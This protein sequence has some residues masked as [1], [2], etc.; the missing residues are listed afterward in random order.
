MILSSHIPSSITDM[1]ELRF[2]ILVLPDHVNFIDGNEYFQRITQYIDSLDLTYDSIW[3]PDHLLPVSGGMKNRI[4]R[5]EFRKGYFECLSLTSYLLPLYPNHKFGQIVLC[6]NFRN[7]ALLAKI[8]STLQVLSNGR[9]ILGLGAGWFPEEHKQYGFDYPSRRKRVERLDEAVK[10][11]KMLWQD[12]DVTFNGK[13]YRIENAFCNPKPDP[14]PP[15]MIGGGG[16]KYTL[17]LVANYADW[18]NGAWYSVE[19]W[20]HKLGVLANHCDDVGRDFDDLVKSALYGISVASTD[21]DALR[22]AKNCPYYSTST[23]ITGGPETLAL[24]LGSL[25]DAGVEFFHL[26]FPQHKY[27]ESAQLFR[28]KVVPLL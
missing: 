6:N 14:C 11:I 22:I 7:P 28:E 27:I 25:V 8:S 26:M 2:G 9:F 18:W 24:K 5:E 1:A 3:I 16:E 10:I 19:T 20:S 17:K 21:E 23:Y 12:D 4:D 15:I 13:H